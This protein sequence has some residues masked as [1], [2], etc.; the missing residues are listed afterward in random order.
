MNEGIINMLNG[1]SKGKKIENS[2]F[3][4][5]VKLKVKRGKMK[6]RKETI[7]FGTKDICRVHT[8]LFM[9]TY[10]YIGIIDLGFMLVR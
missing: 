10:I 4:S 6:K 5:E 8:G 7:L 2:F 1:F 9:Y 3:K